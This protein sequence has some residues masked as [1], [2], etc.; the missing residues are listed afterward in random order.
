MIGPGNGQSARAG[1]KRR[2]EAEDDEDDEEVYEEM[3]VDGVDEDDEDGAEQEDL[4]NKRLRGTGSGQRGDGS[5][6]GP[7]RGK[8]GRSK[9]VEV[10][11]NRA[12]DKEMFRKSRDMK[13]LGKNW[14][15]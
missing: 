15:R 12:V 7:M 4:K 1:E 13:A 8:D 2:R 11:G 14:S 3:V 10:L 6:R 9:R 5:V